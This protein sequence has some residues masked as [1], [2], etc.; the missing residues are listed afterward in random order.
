MNPKASGA[1]IR[2]A[3]ST[4]KKLEDIYAYLAQDLESPVT[5]RRT[6]AAIRKSIGYLRNFP[7]AGPL[8]SSSYGKLPRDLAAVRYFMY[9]S[10]VAIYD[11]SDDTVSILAVFHSLENIY[12][13][14]LSINQP[15]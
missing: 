9:D 11:Y 13:H 1:H 7:E 5:T 6:I 8:L 10:Y 15:E 14:L 3:P 4:V 12:G 2:Y